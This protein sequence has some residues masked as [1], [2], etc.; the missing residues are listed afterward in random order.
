MRA[1]RSKK[2]MGKTR[3][4]RGGGFFSNLFRGV[5]QGDRK[6]IH[7][8]ILDAATDDRALTAVKAHIATNPDDLNLKTGGNKTALTIATNKGFKATSAYLRSMG[9]IDPTRKSL[10]S[11]NSSQNV[12]VNTSVLNVNKRYEATDANIQRLKAEEAKYPY[13]QAFLKGQ[14]TILNGIEKDLISGE[15][16]ADTQAQ[17]QT[18]S[19]KIAMDE[20][21]NKELEAAL[22]SSLFPQK[23]DIPQEELDGALKNMNSSTPEN[24]EEK[25]P[26]LSKFILRILKFLFPTNQSGGANGN[27]EAEAKA[28]TQTINQYEYK[29]LH[30]LKLMFP[31]LRDTLIV[32]FV[33]N[34]DDSRQNGGTRNQRRMRQVGGE[35]AEA[36]GIAFLTILFQAGSCGFVVAMYFMVI[37]ASVAFFAIVNA[38]TIAYNIVMAGFRLVLLNNKKKILNNSYLFRKSSISSIGPVAPTI[39][40]NPMTQATPLPPGWETE[41]DGF[42]HTK[43]YYICNGKSQTEKPTTPCG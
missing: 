43:T 32:M 17:L 26:T 9:G 15:F 14:Q 24:W 11:S 38:S 1:T 13:I 10:F 27:V 6:Q 37:F 20:S 39:F 16:D 7:T 41:S 28:N 8:L 5:R 42:G 30:R 21:L 31:S 2:R 19:E 35:A 29:A 22:P 4:Q 12:S 3:R 40:T 18:L 23:G 36:I 25:Y 34:Y 33:C